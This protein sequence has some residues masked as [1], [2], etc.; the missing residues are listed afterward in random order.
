MFSNGLGTTGPKAVLNTYDTNYNRLVTMADGIGTTTYS[1]YA[2][3]NGQLGAGKLQSVDG[4]WTNDT[5]TYFYDALSRATNRSI[6]GVAQTVTF[7]ALAR[8]TTLTNALGSFT[9]LYVGA[10]ARIATNFYPN[11]QQTIFTYLSNTNDNRLQQIQNLLPNG[12]NLSSFSYAYDSDGQITNWT[13]QADANTPTVFSLGYDSCDQLLSAILTTNTLNGAVLSQYVYDY[14][15]AGNRLSE[16]IQAGS[17]SPASIT[18]GSFNNLNQLTNLN[19]SSGPMLFAGSVSKLANVSVNSS[20]AF[21]NPHN[22]NF[23]GYTTVSVG[24]NV[25]QITATDSYG[26]SRTNNYQIVVT[27]NGI[28]TTLA[29]DL[30]GNEISA[31]TAAS[32]NTYEWDAADRLTAINSGTNRSEFTYDGQGQRVQ[33]IEKQNGTTVS[34]KKFLWCGLEMCEERDSTGSNVTRRFFALGEQISGTNYLSARDHLGSVT[35]MTD[36]AGTIRRRYAYDPYGRLSKIQGDL[37]SDFT[38]TGH[39][40]HRV[41]GLLMASYRVYSADVGRW[42][43]RDPLEERAGLNLY[44]Y[45]GNDPINCVDPLGLSFWSAVGAFVNAAAGTVVVA[46]MVAEVVAASPVIGAALAV[47][48]AG[49]GG[50]RLGIGIQEALTGKDPYTGRQLTTDEIDNAAAGVLGGVV[51]GLFSGK[52]V[53]TRC[54]TPAAETE[55]VASTPVGRLGVPLGRVEAN[56]PTTI[57]GRDYTATRLIRC[58]RVV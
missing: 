15:K 19:G 30:S 32:T 24:S 6:N 48:A 9:N 14:D 7:D 12:A 11:G 29:Y 31:V 39:Y 57:L 43:N 4:P 58:R 47:A 41:S 3:T 17:N 28:A 33:I 22:S 25:V 38:F 51:G 55:A 10:T 49:W 2:V 1:Y 42:L 44:A 52:M 35:E 53:A 40:T 21:V 46:A 54:V 36:T 34:T 13:R 5:V 16:Q 27:N 18:S 45:C 50:Y 56:T 26:N 20:A 37:D 23:V 8:V